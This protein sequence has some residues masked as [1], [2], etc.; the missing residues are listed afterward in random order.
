MFL[1]FAKNLMVKWS[2][3]SVEEGV[4]GV[5]EG[6]VE[7]EVEAEVKINFIG[8]CKSSLWCKLQVNIA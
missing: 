6:F 4:A 7:E 3:V 5:E 2:W 1:L 8:E